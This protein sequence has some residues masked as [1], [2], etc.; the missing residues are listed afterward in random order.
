MFDFFVPLV[1]DTRV[2]KNVNISIFLQ[3]GCKFFCLLCC[4]K[5][6]DVDA[7]DRCLRRGLRANL[8]SRSYYSKCWYGV[9]TVPLIFIPLI[10]GCVDQHKSG[11]EEIVS[12][13][14]KTQEK[15][16]VLM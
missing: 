16:I 8:L 2:N 13:T 9:S 4:V 3:N 6:L 1:S 15:D 10:L 12:E 14:N 5:S 7:E 11:V